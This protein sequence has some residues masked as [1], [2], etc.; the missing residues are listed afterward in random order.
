MASFLKLSALIALAATLQT[1]VATPP[2]CLLA[3]VAQVEKASSCNGLNDLSCICS[4]DASKIEAC[5]KDICPNDNADD[6]ITAFEGSC[7]DSGNNVNLSSVAESSSTE[8]SSST[9]E[10]S[11][12]EETSSTEESSS[13]E[14]TTSSTEETS[15]TEAATTSS[16]VEETS[17]TEETT[18]S[19]KATSTA[20]ET[21]SAATSSVVLTSVA[22]AET[23]V[24]AEST[25]AAESSTAEIPTP[26]QGAA[27]IKQLSFGAAVAGLVG[28]ALL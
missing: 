25:S 21:S 23:S 10:S 6:A 2:A 20:E 5:L 13:T 28:I 26:S 18:S 16:T 12:T 3:C 27:G 8:E 17:S 4:N 15:S 14:A 9:Q 1:A 24:E 19:A 11:S 7:K 22:A